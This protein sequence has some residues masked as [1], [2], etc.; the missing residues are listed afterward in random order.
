[1]G[2]ALWAQSQMEAQ[3]GIVLLP[4]FLIAG[5]PEPVR[6][7][8]SLRQQLAN[9]VM[10]SF[11]DQGG[12]PL[13]N[14]NAPPTFSPGFPP[15]F[16]PGYPALPPPAY[17]P[18][19]GFAVPQP[20]MGTL[21]DGA[22]P[23]FPPPL[24]SQAIHSADPASRIA[25]FH[26]TAFSAAFIPFAV[27]VLAPGPAVMLLGAVAGIADGLAALMPGRVQLTG[28]FPSGTDDDRASEAAADY[29][30]LVDR[31]DLTAGWLPP[32]NRPDSATEGVSRLRSFAA[33]V[34]TARVSTEGDRGRV[35]VHRIG[36][37][38]ATAGYHA[39]LNTVPI[40]AAKYLTSPTVFTTE[41]H[42]VRQVGV[43]ADTARQIR[44][45][46]GR[47]ASFLAEPCS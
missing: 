28:N 29:Q 25:A 6:A 27:T 39:R 33:L 14:V 34:G 46:G 40:D 12:I 5:M 41:G 13:I 16:L 45:H 42:A 26:S 32:P 19:L 1:M 20:P 7:G 36:H 9:R 44:M 37:V 11:P 21:A 10:P 18:P 38:S 23:I 47:A 35:A 15:G 43:I 31:P 3:Q 30:R 4:A 2:P 8:R 22:Q 17:P 24:I